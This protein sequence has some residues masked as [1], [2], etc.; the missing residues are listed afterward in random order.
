ML[1]RNPLPT[2]DMA[3]RPLVLRRR[4]HPA[5]QP[6]LC[7][8]FSAIVRT[9]NGSKSTA[10]ILE[11]LESHTQV[12]VTTVN[13][14]MWLSCAAGTSAVGFCP[15]GRSDGLIRVP[16]YVVNCPLVSMSLRHLRGS[17]RRPPCAACQ[18][19]SLSA[20]A[21]NGYGKALRTRPSL[22]NLGRPVARRRTANG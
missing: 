13:G 14:R 8:A 20:F 19:A 2:P 12:A 16:V 17:H 6:N 4:Y 11:A 22:M 3:E 9:D 7:S 15:I 1:K 10:P 5:A 21:A 18:F